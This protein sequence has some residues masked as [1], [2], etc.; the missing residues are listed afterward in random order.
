LAAARLFIVAHRYGFPGSAADE[1]SAFAA[2][3]FVLFFPGSAP[4]ALR[5]RHALA[6][7]EGIDCLP[8]AMAL[9]TAGGGKFSTISRRVHSQGAKL[10]QAGIESVI[11]NLVRIHC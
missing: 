6:E 8:S 11:V 5:T 4:V 9:I 2:P 10:F 3:C 1:G 7:S